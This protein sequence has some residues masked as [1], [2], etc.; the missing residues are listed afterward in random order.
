[1]TELQVYIASLGNAINEYDVFKHTF[2]E[3]YNSTKR[4]LAQIIDLCGFVVELNNKLEE[5]NSSD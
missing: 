3:D 2:G 4:A 5:G 1:M